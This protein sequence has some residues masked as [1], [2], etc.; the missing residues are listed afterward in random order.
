[1][2]YLSF[3][4]IFCFLSCSES[5][6]LSLFSGRY[7]IYFSFHDFE[8]VKSKS[9]KRIYDEVYRTSRIDITSEYI[10]IS[11]RA[12]TKLLHLIRKEDMSYIGDFGEIGDGPEEF[13]SVNY[14]C[15]KVADNQSVLFSGRDLKLVFFSFPS[16][17]DSESLRTLKPDSILMKS[18][19][20]PEARVINLLPPNRI[21]G[22]S[23]GK[24]RFI[25]KDLKTQEI[26]A[27]IDDWDGLLPEADLPI[28]VMQSIFQGRLA[29][30]PSGDY[31]GHSKRYWDLIEIYNLKTGNWIR[32]Y[33][34]DQLN[35]TYE[36]ETSSGYPMHYFEDSENKIAYYDL[37][38][39]NKYIYALYSGIQVAP[40]PYCY[41]THLL[42]FDYA[43][44]PVKTFELDVTVA[45]NMAID[46]EK[47]MAYVAYNEK[48]NGGIAR[49]PLDLP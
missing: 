44:N 20:L 31:I 22:L 10:I 48:D 28:H 35:H 49:F 12:N 41:A 15:S 13:L 37:K 36:I 23:S 6:E 7:L 21:F 8:K 3:I 39:G 17:L 2:K 4:L 38:L 27:A 30:N 24:E 32:L 47:N 5:T 26:V 9:E 29:T 14:F 45:Y 46:E 16:G 1:M 33:G 11:D 25:V 18:E 19:L 42:V 34:P 40:E 43:G